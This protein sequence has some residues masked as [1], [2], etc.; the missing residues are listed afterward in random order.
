MLALIPARSG[1]VRVPNKNIKR[2]NGHPLI[3]YAI[4][5]ALS[6]KLFSKVIVCTDSHIYADVAKYY[7]AIVPEL[8]PREISTSTSP[9]R[10][11]IHWILNHDKV[12]ASNSKYAFILRPTNPFR[13]RNTILRAYNALT[14][15]N[16]DTLRAVRKVTEH[17][18][19]MWVKQGDHIVPLIPLMHDSV[20]FHSNQTNCLFDVYVQDASLEI[21][22]IKQFDLTGQI[23]GSSII[24]FESIGIEGYDINYPDDFRQAEILAAHNPSLL[25]SINKSPIL[26]PD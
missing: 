12:K 26:L 3:A 25:P 11:W 14:N 19:K 22:S 20:P 21:F 24:P 23:T 7:G 16:A 4:Y 10:E 2:L 5:E 9:D 8:R 6:S 1:S 17:P 18:G 13:T 15:S